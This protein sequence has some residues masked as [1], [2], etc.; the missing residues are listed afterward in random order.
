MDDTHRVAQE[1]TC[2]PLVVDLD[3]TLVKTDLLVESFFSLLSTSPAA[4]LRA[5]RRLPFGWAAFKARLAELARIDF[6]KIPLNEEL[7][8]WLVREKE[9]GRRIYLASASSRPFVQ[10]MADALGLFDGIFASDRE[11][12]LKGAAKAAALCRAFGNGGFDYV[13][14]DRADLAVWKHAAAVLVTNAGAGLLQ[15]VRRR[16]PDATVLAPHDASWTDY[17]RALRPHQWVKNLLVFVPAVTAH[18]FDLTVALACLIAFASFNLCASSAYV[19]ND[20]L[21]MGND[22]EHPWKRRRPFA[23]ARVDVR[24]GMLLV[25]AA[26]G[27]SLISGLLV[28][29][30]FV[31]VLCF[32][33]A[34]TLAYSVYLKRQMMLDAVTLASLY[35][36]RLL[37]G[38]LAAGVPLSPW[39]AIFAIFLFLSLALV[40]RSSELAGRLATGAGDPAGRGYRLTD[41]PVLQGLAASSGYVAVLIFGLYI[42]S[43]TVAALYR[44]PDRLWAISVILLYWISRVLILTHRGE[45]HEDP[46]LFASKDPT[47][48]IC[49]GLMIATLMASMW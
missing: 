32:Y 34:L 15:T 12:N 47:S 38:A 27:L 35:G 10:G 28:S 13:G 18:R 20:L 6:R 7:V 16:F 49:A 23:A 40:K 39:M 21:D 42:N 14:N 31:A 5:L 1:K 44:T 2:K 25:P 41:L 26:L 29:R 30:T 46:V 24:H 43:P 45:M 33:Y 37:A 48:L 17:L 9:R 8:A 11:V 19:L 36:I 3:G 4:V 22:R